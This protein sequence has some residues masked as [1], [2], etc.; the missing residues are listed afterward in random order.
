MFTAATIAMIGLGVTAAGVGT[1]MYAMSQQAK[2]Q[3]EMSLKQQEAEAIR[4]Q[5]MNLES[6]RR[7]REV[8]RNAQTSSAMAVAAA[9][10]QGGAE[11]SGLTGA[12]ATISGR[13][14]GSLL[15][16]SQ[17]EELGTKMFGIN[18]QMAALQGERAGYESMSGMGSGMSSLG[19]MLVKNQNEIH[20]IGT[21]F[22][23]S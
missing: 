23:G 18:S 20:S 12:L 13:S 7:K 6:M 10:N 8:I 2:V 1:Q 22:F 4:Q 19:G 3:K 15:A 17:N 21:K 14:G 11:S 9:S 16:T 5:Q